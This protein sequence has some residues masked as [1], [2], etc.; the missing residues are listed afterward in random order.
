MVVGLSWHCHEVLVFFFW[1]IFLMFS[2][3][4]QIITV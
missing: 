4:G 1:L 2:H 3:H